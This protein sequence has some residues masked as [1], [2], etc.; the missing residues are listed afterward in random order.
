MMAGPSNGLLGRLRATRP[1]RLTRPGRALRG[2]SGYTLV[3]LLA[4]LV[5]L[6]LMTA[7]VSTGVSAGARAYERAQFSS[8]ADML[9]ATVNTALS[10]AFRFMYEDGDSYVITHDGVKV[11]FAKG[12]P[13][14]Q[15]NG[16]HRFRLVGADVDRPLVNDGTYGACQVSDVTMESC[17]MSGV[18]YS[19]SLTNGGSL[20][21]TYS[22]TATP[23]QGVQRDRGVRS[24]SG[25][26]SG[27]EDAETADKTALNA[28]IARVEA[29]DLSGENTA[30]KAALQTA[31]A[32]AKAVAENEGASQEEVDEAAAA[33]AAARRAYENS[34]SDAPQF[35]MSALE[36]AIGRAD[37]ERPWKRENG[38]D[39]AVAN[40]EGAY[41]AAKD[42]LGGTGV[43]TQ[44]DVDGVAAALDDALEAYLASLPGGDDDDGG[45]GDDG[46]DILEGIGEPEADVAIDKALAAR[47]SAIKNEWE[48]ERYLWKKQA[49][50]DGVNYLACV[51][52]QCAVVYYKGTYYKS[53]GSDEV[54]L[55]TPLPTSVQANESNWKSAFSVGD[56]TDGVNRNYGYGSL[57]WVVI[58]KA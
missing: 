23:L 10:D 50:K 9:S 8:Q 14:L 56:L 3:E 52:Q 11:A 17:T 20:T 39:Q 4:A 26:P 21:R 28:E 24:G 35:D 33:L 30:P 12:S 27:G 42:A 53:V 36:A 29:I 37:A 54:D 32:A 55:V 13:V 18:K 15:A 51:W 34:L 58:A 45:G 22:F 46:G 44:E 48:R 41:A 49:D 38:N 25:S 6:S 43:A 40:L 57:H 7:M 5:V 19:Y 47:T 31:L 2:R 16:E 1:T